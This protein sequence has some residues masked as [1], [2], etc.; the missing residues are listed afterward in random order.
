MAP[1]F[2]EVI[3]LEDGVSAFSKLGLDL[4]TMNHIPKKAMKIVIKP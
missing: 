4:N 3:R 1:F 2:T